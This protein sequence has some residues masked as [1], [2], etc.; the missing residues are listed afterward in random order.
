MKTAL[1][2]IMMALSGCTVGEAVLGAGAA[3]LGGYLLGR[4]DRPRTEYRRYQR[5]E[6]HGNHVHCWD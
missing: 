2:I 1:L 4:E 6:Q 3:G 5:C